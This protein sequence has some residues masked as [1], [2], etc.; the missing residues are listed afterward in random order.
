MC[1]LEMAPEGWWKQTA[2]SLVGYGK[3]FGFTLSELGRLQ[4]V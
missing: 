4:K 2:Q 1:R 3:D